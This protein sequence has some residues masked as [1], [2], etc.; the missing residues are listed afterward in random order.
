MAARNIQKGEELT[1]VPQDWMKRCREERKEM[2]R[3]HNSKCT[4][5]A[6]PPLG[7]LSSPISFSGAILVPTHEGLHSF[8]IYYHANVCMHVL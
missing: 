2:E 3:E 6:T 8:L 7:L 4:P 5:R 1:V